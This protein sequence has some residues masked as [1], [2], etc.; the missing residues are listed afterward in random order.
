VKNDGHLK[1]TL[2]FFK[3]RIPNRVCLAKIFRTF[4]GEMKNGWKN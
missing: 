1:S 4:K 3:S 2:P